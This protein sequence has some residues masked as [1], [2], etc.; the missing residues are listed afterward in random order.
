[1]QRGGVGRTPLFFEELS[2]IIQ[3]LPVYRGVRFPPRG[4]AA[5]EGL[6]SVV[7]GGPGGAL[8]I[9]THLG[10]YSLIKLECVLPI[11]SRSFRFLGIIFSE[12]PLHLGVFFSLFLLLFGRLGASCW[13]KFAKNSKIGG[14][15]PC[16]WV[17]SWK[18]KSRNINIFQQLSSIFCGFG[19][20]EF[21]MKTMLLFD[22]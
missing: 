15:Y 1:M 20:N 17:A 8:P 18:Y 16:I 2:A 3:H 12:N 9:P 10:F 22:F 14:F 6:P 19:N 21:D 4:R 5:R 11:V 7:S 13:P